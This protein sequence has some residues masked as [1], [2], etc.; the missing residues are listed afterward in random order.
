LNLD[1]G[2]EV[3]E[4]DFTCTLRQI[5]N[6]KKISVEIEKRDEFV[7]A[8][9]KNHIPEHCSFE[10]E[11]MIWLIDIYGSYTMYNRRT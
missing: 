5:V 3:L 8:L 7:A 6:A 4:F 9:I 10:R 2:K 11:L 1:R